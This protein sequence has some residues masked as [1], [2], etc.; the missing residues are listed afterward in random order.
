MKEQVAEIVTAYLRKNSVAPTDVAAVITQV[1]Q[2]LA[3]VG[4]PQTMEPVPAVPIRRSVTPEFIICLECGAKGMMLKP[5]REPPRHVRIFKLWLLGLA[6]HEQ[7]NV[8]CRGR[9]W[10]RAAGLREPSPAP[11]GIRRDGPIC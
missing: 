11:A 6:Q 1:Y 10:V 9:C 2:S 8:F 7:L 5:P 3:T 4:Q